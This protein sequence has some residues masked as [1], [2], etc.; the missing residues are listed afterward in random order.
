M[1]SGLNLKCMRY[2]KHL[3]M[4]LLCPV[5]MSAQEVYF[6]CDFSAYKDTLNFTVLDRDKNP[7][8][9]DIRNIKFT[10]GSWT[11][12]VVDDP[13]NFAAIS[14]SRCEND[15]PVD[16][17]M[18]INPVSITSEN[19][20]LKWEAKSIHYDFRDSYK[21]MISTKTDDPSDFI[22]VYSVEE[23]NYFWA[24]H[25]I[26]LKDYVGQD[27]YVAFVNVSRNKFLLA[28]DNIY[29]GELSWVKLLVDDNTSRTADANQPLNI[30]G[31]IVNKGKELFIN[32]ID[33]SVEDNIYSMDLN[34]I[35]KPNETIEYSFEI[36]VT[37][38]EH[39]NYEISAESDTR[40]TLLSDKTYITEYKRVLLAEEY[41]AQWCLGCPSGTLY[42]HKFEER[43]KKDA[44]IVTV[45]NGNDL[46][47]ATYVA[48]LTGVIYSLPSMYYDREYIDDTNG[49]QLDRSEVRRVGQG[50]RLWCQ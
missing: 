24:N 20:Y 31:T 36:P 50:G 14:G 16:D 1:L 34:R 22:E 44:A 29:M 9:K 27:I 42:M 17:W 28:I 26:S 18:I 35:V 47:D 3:I 43:Y 11:M 48:G 5:T 8:L 23:E 38:N 49:A 40:H 39:I 12:N 33:C 32:S 37:V 10:N 46:N 19:S 25:L 4:A 21:V 15:A 13:G 41:T 6:N 45:Y 2:I 7:H 30:N